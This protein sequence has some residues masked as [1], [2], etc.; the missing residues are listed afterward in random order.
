METVDS[1]HMRTINSNILF[2]MIWQR[3]ETSRA[4]ISRITGMSRSSVSAIV[5]ELMDRG[6]VS[7]HGI[8]TSNGG[9]RPVMLSLNSDAYRI[10]GIDIGATHVSSLLMDLKGVIR[11]FQVVPCAVQ[12]N[13][14]EALSVLIQSI[15]GMKDKAENE[16]SPLIGIGVG[17]P[18]PVSPDENQSPM[19]AAI[20]PAWSNVDLRTILKENFSL[21]LVFEN[22]ANLGALAELWWSAGNTSGN[23][24]YIKMGTGLGAGLVING[25]VYRGSRGLSG[26]MGHFLQ[27]NTQAIQGNLNDYLSS[28]YIQKR[29]EEICQTTETSVLY[30][31]VP[32]VQAFADALAVHDKVAEELLEEFSFRLGI[33]IVNLLSLLDLDRIILGGSLQPCGEFLLNRVR[34]VIERKSVWKRNVELRWSQIGDHQIAVGAATMILDKALDDLSLFP[35]LIGATQRA[36]LGL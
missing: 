14:V 20:L 2:K 8:G 7:E 18:C 10:L 21:P 16:G 12:T 35:K 9:R 34:Q 15:H 31:Q 6:L 26:E 5:S 36:E 28:S 11:D 32:S 24:G 4:D 19:N 33:A 13:P 27:T 29:I 1:T 30:G 3:Q 23:L 25:R 22:D 17:L